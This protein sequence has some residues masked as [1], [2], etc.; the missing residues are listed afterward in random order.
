MRAWRD[1]AAVGQNCAAPLDLACAEGKGRCSAKTP[2][3]YT[4]VAATATGNA[5]SATQPCQLGL[6]CLDGALTRAKT[7]GAPGSTCNLADKCWDGWQCD[8]GKCAKTAKVAP[9]TC[10]DDAVCPTTHTCAGGACKAKLC[11]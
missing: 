4:C 5:C 9:A 7:C 1:P 11:P 8:N 2:D 10:A 6:E 3:L